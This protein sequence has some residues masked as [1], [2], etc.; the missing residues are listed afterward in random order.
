MKVM[1]AHRAR[2]VVLRLDRGEELPAALT[3]AREEAGVKSAWLEVLGTLAAAGMGVDDARPRADDKARGSCS[4]LANDK[5]K[6]KRM[7]NTGLNA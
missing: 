4:L 5:D 1:E 7:F 3:R 2:H 6:D